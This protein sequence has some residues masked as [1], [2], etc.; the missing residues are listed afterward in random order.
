MNYTYK[1]LLEIHEDFYEMLQ[2][3]FLLWLLEES[4]NEGY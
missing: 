1:E 4:L 3:D 2:A